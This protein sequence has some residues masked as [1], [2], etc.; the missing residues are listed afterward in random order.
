MDKIESFEHAGSTMKATM[1]ADQLIQHVTDVLAQA[2]GEFIAEIANKV[3]SR[4]VRYVGEQ[5]GE[6]V[7]EQ[8]EEPK[9]TP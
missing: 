9:A 1:T 6:T 3:L 2:D 4:P 5:D 8:V 7:F